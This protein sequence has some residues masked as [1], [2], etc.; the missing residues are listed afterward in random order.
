MKWLWRWSYPLRWPLKNW[1]NTRQERTR[2]LLWIIYGK[3]STRAL[4]KVLQSIARLPHFQIAKIS[5]LEGAKWNTV[6]PTSLT[7]KRLEIL[8][9][10]VSDASSNTSTSNKLSKE[11]IL[12][13]IFIVIQSLRHYR[14]NWPTNISLKFRITCKPNSDL[15]L[16]RAWSPALTT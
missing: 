7:L 6:T 16:S 12:K 2:K 1:K 9:A 14:L 10:V 11:V 8:L 4:L 15:R 13:T 5:K 3:R